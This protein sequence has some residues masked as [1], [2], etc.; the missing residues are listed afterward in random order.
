MIYKLC[1]KVIL[2]GNFA[3]EDMKKKIDVYFLCNRITHDQ[4]EELIKLIDE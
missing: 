4:Y 3:K 2:N 1:K